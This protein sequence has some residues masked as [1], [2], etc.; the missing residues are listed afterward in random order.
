MRITE[1]VVNL[2]CVLYVVHIAVVDVHN[3]WL[4]NAVDLL[5]DNSPD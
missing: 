3:R 4:F 1:R 2:I 5:F